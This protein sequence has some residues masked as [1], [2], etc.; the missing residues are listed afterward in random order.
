MLLREAGIGSVK[1]HPIGLL[2]HVLHLPKLIVSLISVQKI[3]KM[4]EYMIIRSTDGRLDLLQ[5]TMDTIT[6]LL[7]L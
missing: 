1:L 6:Y 4:N 2:T 7:H 3:A 5:S